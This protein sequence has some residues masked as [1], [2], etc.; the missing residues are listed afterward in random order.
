M[1]V[2][3]VLRG[4]DHLTNTPRQMLIIEALGLKAP[5]YGHVS[6]LV[7]DDGVPLS[8]RH[9]ASTVRE[10]R[11]R[12][13]LPLA[14]VNLLFR[15]GHST[16]EH[17]VLTLPAMA[18]AFDPRH[19]GRSPA[20]FDL[21]QLHAWQ[22][23]VVHRL[24]PAEAAVWLE[25]AL[26][27]VALPSAAEAQAREAFLHAVLPNVVLPEDARRWSGVLYGEAPA[28]SEADLAVVRE[29]GTA[30][31]QAAARAA[32]S[33]DLKVIAAAAREVTGRKGPA[34][35]LPLRLALTGLHHGPELAPL[36]RAMAPAKIEERFAR[37]A[38]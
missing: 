25:T 5:A 6:L 1:A 32:A 22:K 13:F 14:V 35:F 37:F 12:G 27:A 2:T 34:L 21:Q 29:A 17:G 15:L 26:P 28:L 7:G 16:S 33:S 31:F 10:L 3:H 24:A 8:K 11:E 4:E 9:G 23:E 20:R 38:Q 18:E 36:L 19:L 30:F